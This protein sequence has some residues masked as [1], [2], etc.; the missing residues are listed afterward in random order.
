MVISRMRGDEKGHLDAHRRKIFCITQNLTKLEKLYEGE[1]LIQPFLAMQ[2]RPALHGAKMCRPNAR[3]GWEEP[4][5]ARE[6]TVGEIRSPP[7][8]IPLYLHLPTSPSEAAPPFPPFL[9]LLP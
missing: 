7:A 9:A 5:H 8:D 4:A 3:E 1:Y 2:P 6:N